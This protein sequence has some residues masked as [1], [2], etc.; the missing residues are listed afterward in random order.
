[1]PLEWPTVHSLKT[2]K[3]KPWTYITSILSIVNEFWLTS[4]L[5]SSVRVIF[6]ILDAISHVVYKH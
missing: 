4:A 5:Q 3:G 6:L 2:C 1:M